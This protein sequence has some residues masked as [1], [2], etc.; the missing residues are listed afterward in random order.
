MN[1]KDLWKHWF[2]RPQTALTAAGIPTGVYHYQRAA[3]GRTARFHLRVDPSGNGLLLANAK[4]AVRLHPS[5][6]ILTKGLLER[7]DEAALLEK[8]ARV[9]RGV[10]IEHARADL[11]DVRELIARLEAPGDNFPLFS[12]GDL[13]FSPENVPLERPISADVPLSKPFYM[14]AILERLWESGIPH[15]TIIA[16]KNPAEKELI[17]AVEKA[18]KLGI[19]AGVRGFG[20]HLSI[21]TRIA[22]LAAAGLDHLDVVCLSIDEKIHDSLT[23]PGD[24][25]LAIKSLVTAQKRGICPVAVIP[26]PRVALSKIDET[27]AALATHGVRNVF[28]LAFTTTEENPA[29]SEV[30]RADELAPAMGM[31]EEVAAR[32]AIRAIWYPSVRRNFELSLAEQIFRGPRTSG[33]GSVRVEPDG[34]VFAARGP[35]EPAGNLLEDSWEKIAASRVYRRFRKHVEKHLYCKKCPNLGFCVADCANP[36]EGPEDEDID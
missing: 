8:I 35:A 13:S 9:F 15:V 33:D 5:G 10:S 14:D 29:A 3:D 25:R 1:I 4:S 24:Y 30:F 23:A 18:E 28:L 16:G 17:R 2:S 27:L 6:V 34:R 36:V 11:A 31:I 20:A 21:G 22:D 32:H 7:Q 12:T 19:I 26:L